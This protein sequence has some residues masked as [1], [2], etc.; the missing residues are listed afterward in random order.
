MVSTAT[1]TSLDVMEIARTPLEARHCALAVVDIQQ[2]LLPPIFEKERMVR[3]S[4][5]L[6][7]L[8]KI[9]NLPVL[10]STQ[11]VPSDL[12]GFTTRNWTRFCSSFGSTWRTALA[13]LSFS[14]CPLMCGSLLTS[15]C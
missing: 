11:Y 15:K 1:P 13:C 3:N 14:I 9:L 2:K 7:R 4:Q 6:I 8:A 5:L 10:L 12:F